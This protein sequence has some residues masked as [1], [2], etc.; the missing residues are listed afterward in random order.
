MEFARMSSI[1]IAVFLNA[2]A[3][4][5]T[6][7]SLIFGLWIGTITRSRRISTTTELL[8]ERPM[9]YTNLAA[10]GSTGFLM[11]ASRN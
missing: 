6:L 1:A 11:D 9:V 3:F 8:S 5:G 2:S 10:E 4:A 7:P